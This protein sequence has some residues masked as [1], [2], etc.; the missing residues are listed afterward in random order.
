V[1]T[2]ECDLSLD[3]AFLPADYAW[4]GR[5]RRLKITSSSRVVADLLV[6][7]LNAIH[8]RV[9]V[10]R[11]G[12]GRFDP[13]EGVLGAV[14]RLGTLVTA[15]G[16]DGAFDFYNLPLGSHTVTLETDRLPAAFSA[17]LRSSIT[18]ELRDDRPVTGADFIVTARAKPVNW[19]RIQ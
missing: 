18:A 14:V 13:D 12:N 1:P 10:D 19:R 11:D 16:A 7:P 4:D 17:G 9:Y 5:S 15:T 2:G 8:G 3:P 6:A